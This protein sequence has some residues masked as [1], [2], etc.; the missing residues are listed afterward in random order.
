MSGATV[1]PITWLSTR[2]CPVRMGEVEDA[3]LMAAQVGQ[4]RRVICASPA[5]LARRGR[6]GRPEDLAAHDAI[7][8]D[9]HASAGQWSFFRGA[10]P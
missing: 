6:P 5:Y 7:L 10:T 9:G 2:P 1:A 4:V 3:S 8:S